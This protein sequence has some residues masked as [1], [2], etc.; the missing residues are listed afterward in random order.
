[1]EQ[2]IY[3]MSLEHPAGPERK[4]ALKKQNYGVYQRDKGA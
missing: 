4:E 2:E 1:M 3:K